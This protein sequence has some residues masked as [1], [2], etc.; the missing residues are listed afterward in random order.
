MLNSHSIITQVCEIKKNINP[1][2]RCQA[3]TLNQ[4]NNQKGM[5]KL[6]KNSIVKFK[7]NPIS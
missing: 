3:F 1:K 6:S 2:K 7:A 4:Q 5:K